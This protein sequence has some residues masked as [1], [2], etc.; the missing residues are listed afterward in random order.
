MEGPERD[1]SEEFREGYREGDQKS[2]QKA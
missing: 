2:Y 1:V